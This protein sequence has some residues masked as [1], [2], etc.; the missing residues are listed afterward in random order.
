MRRPTK[1]STRVVPKLVKPTEPRQ[2]LEPKHKLATERKTTPIQLYYSPTILCERP[3]PHG[4]QPLSGPSEGRTPDER[5][6]YPEPR[7]TRSSSNSLQQHRVLPM[8]T[9]GTLRM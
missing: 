1:R 6:S 8:W 5:E 3:S 4:P 7:F 9:N 2:S